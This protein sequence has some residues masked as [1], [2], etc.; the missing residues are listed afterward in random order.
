MGMGRT[1]ELIKKER[2]TAQGKGTPLR[3][4]V[5]ELNHRLEMFTRIL[6]S[7]HDGVMVIDA[8]GFI[9][10][11]NRHYYKFLDLPEGS[12]IG[13]HCTKIVENTR[14]H[15]VAKTGIPEINRTHEI[16]GQEMI[17]QRIP[18][19]EK[20][21]IVAVYG[22]IIFKNVKDIKKLAT[23]LSQL[24]SKVK[25]YE[26]ELINLRST[27]YTLESIIGESRIV[28]G[29]KKEALKA[30]SNKFS[31]LITGESG[32]GKELFA[33]AIHHASPRKLQP[34]V[35][36]NCAAIP[37]QLLESELFGYE[38]GAFTGAKP[39]GKP[40]KFELADRGSIFLDEIGELPLEMQPKLL[41]VLEEKEFERVGG[42]RII[43]SDF[44]LIAAT[45][46]DLEEMMKKGGFR[47]DLFYRLNVIS[48]HIPP[49][50][51]RR[52][53]I[54]PL[55]HHLL[56]NMAYD[57]SFD[58]IEIS[59]E[60]ERVLENYDWP[61]NVRELTNVL[62]RIISSMEGDEIRL[63][64]LP[65]YLQKI[66]VRRPKMPLS[67]LKQA[68]VRAE[69]DVITRSLAKVDYN[70]TRAA[71]LL[72]V[73]RTLLYKKMEKYGIPLEAEPLV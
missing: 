68:Q 67:T 71:E 10:H 8:D 17:V 42:N 58:N 27:R 2:K 28:Q 54:L 36:I 38:K 1:V 61:G 31:V 16:K 57:V 20:G 39:G 53:D 34:F 6:D 52:E 24:E 32:T 73:H 12:V 41:R 66:K 65:F 70:K 14:L 15:I 60:A 4:G 48:L 63:E 23:K 19:R 22:Q 55:S 47:R 59:K 69:I 11:F 26:Q 7:I 35:R 45:N 40:G 64:N 13:K 29:L 30:T 44:R 51:E 62:E 50:R 33:Q 56:K 5:K 21:K 46:R 25:L 9:T 3:P 43:R 37:A 49:L 72:G 18:I